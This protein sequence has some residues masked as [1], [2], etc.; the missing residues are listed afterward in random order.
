MSLSVAHLGPQGTNAET[1]A[2]AYAHWLNHH[3]HTARLLKF[4]YYQTA[5]LLDFVCTGK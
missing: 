2:L 3:Q 5:G 1:A 4:L